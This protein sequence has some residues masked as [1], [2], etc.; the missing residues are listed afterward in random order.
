MRS[1]STPATFD[2][3]NPPLLKR[4]KAS[5][6][7]GG[8][9]CAAFAVLSVLAATFGCGAEVAD[10]VPAVDTSLTTEALARPPVGGGGGVTPRKCLK[11]EGCSTSHG[12]NACCE[13]VEVDCSVVR[14]DG[15]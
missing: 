10:P 2:M 6:S 14:A 3:M 4:S 1:G 7:S 5:K 15:T 9:G 8:R 13:V 11:C 12:W